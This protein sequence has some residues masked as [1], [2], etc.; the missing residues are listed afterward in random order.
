MFY[1]ME[2][3]DFFNQTSVYEQVGSF[4]LFANINNTLMNIPD[5]DFRELIQLAPMVDF[6]LGSLPTQV[7]LCGGI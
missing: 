5:I 4:Q 7:I 1:H 6:R 2:C 3:H